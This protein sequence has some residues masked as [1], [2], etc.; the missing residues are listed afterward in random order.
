[1]ATSLITGA[2]GFI[3]QHLAAALRKQGHRV[4]CLVRKTSDVRRLQELSCELAFGDVTD[5]ESL[6]VAMREARPDCV[7]HLAGLT[8]ATRRQRL[9]EV[10]ERGTH[11]LLTTAASVK[12]PPAVAVVSTLAVAGPANNGNAKR[13]PDTPT[14]VSFYGKSKLAGERVAAAFA[15]KVPISIVRPPIV[16]GPYDR[17]GFE[18][19][20]SVRNMGIH[21]VPSRTGMSVSWIHANDLVQALMRVMDSGQRLG[22][23][24]SGDG[25]YFATSD[26]VVTYTELGQMIGQA[27]GRERVKTLYAP[28]FMVWGLA[29]INET[30]SRINGRPNIMNFDKARE[31]TAGSWICSGEKLATEMGFTCD[32]SL[33]ETLES[34]VRWYREAGWLR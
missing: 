13:E 4:V 31:A 29:A 12:S 34:C 33:R 32:L 2:S 3:G 27:L 1:M 16:L 19:F 15:G 7:Y 25:V 11:N 22:D 23:L 24:S 5:L 6:K 30:I 8:K 28:S 21:A 20:K 9:F 14:P 26:E 18:M 17:D 10:N